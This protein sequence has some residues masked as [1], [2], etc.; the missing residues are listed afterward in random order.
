MPRAPRSSRGGLIYHVVNYA[1]GPGPLF[2]SD[3]DFAAFADALGLAAEAVGMRVVG[4][5][6]MPDHFHLVLWPR[7]D[8]DLSR[9]MQ[10]LLTGHARRRQ[11][12]RG[13]TGSLWHGRFKA[14]PI[15][16]DDHLLTALH[17]VESNPVRSR[18]IS[19]ARNWPW[20]SLA[21][22]AGG[23]TPDWLVD[24]PRPRPPGWVS[25]I[26][27]PLPGDELQRLKTC[28][29]RNRPYGSPA[30]ARRIAAR[31]GIT[32]SLN[33]LGRPPKRTASTTRSRT[34]RGASG[35][36]AAR[37]TQRKSPRKKK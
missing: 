18:L 34:T 2:R 9:F 20:S 33:P 4:Y 1:A 30:W 23:K 29:Y 24:G 11:A 21:V 25:R 26:N 13:K 31:L 37:P 12:L 35:R 10:R 17:F 6:I 27:Q 14:F 16:P 7:R 28:I 19:N 36:T 22:R 32:P 8:G 5:C 3:D 15:Q